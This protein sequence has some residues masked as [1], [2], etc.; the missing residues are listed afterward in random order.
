MSDLH[1]RRGRTP[2]IGE[3]VTAELPYENTTNLRYCPLCS[4]VT[5]FSAGACEFSEWH[6]QQ[7]SD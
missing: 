2:T 6:E 3:R 4:C 5:R 1:A 7:R